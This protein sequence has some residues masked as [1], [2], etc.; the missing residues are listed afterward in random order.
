MRRR[1][2]IAAGISAALVVAVG[3]GFGSA[4]AKPSGSATEP[5]GQMVAA[6]AQ[7][8]GSSNGETVQQCQAMHEQMDQ[9]MDGYMGSSGMMG[10]TGSNSTGWNS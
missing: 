10:G 6:C 7:M 9:M 8:H 2:W 5:T 3:V 4:Q 1:A